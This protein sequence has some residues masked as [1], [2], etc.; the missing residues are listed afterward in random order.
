MKSL[1]LVCGLCVG[2]AVIFHSAE[3]AG[4]GTKRQRTAQ[5]KPYARYKTPYGEIRFRH[6]KGRPLTRV[7]GHRGYHGKMTMN[8]I[9]YGPAGMPQAP[10]DFGPYFDYPAA[11]LNSGP[12]AA[13]YPH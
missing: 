5:S 7:A 8:G 10:R 6:Y 12:T 3:T 9:L 4:A 11:P 1:M 13:P 2:L